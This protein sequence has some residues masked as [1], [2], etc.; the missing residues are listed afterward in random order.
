[1]VTTDDEHQPM[2]VDESTGSMAI[3][4]GGERHQKIATYPQQPQGKPSAY[5]FVL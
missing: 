5:H 3:E 2:E 4:T 1:M